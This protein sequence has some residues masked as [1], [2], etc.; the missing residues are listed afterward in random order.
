MLLGGSPCHPGAHWQSRCSLMQSPIPHWLGPSSGLTDQE[1][2]QRCGE[3]VEELRLWP[4]SLWVRGWRLEGL[5][6]GACHQHLWQHFHGLVSAFGNAVVCP[7]AEPCHVASAGVA[8][9]LPCLH[10][11]CQLGTWGTEALR[12]ASLSKAPYLGAK[13]LLEV[14]LE[15]GTWLEG[16]SQSKQE[17]A[18][19]HL[20]HGAMALLWE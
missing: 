9:R 8:P 2:W 14:S 4:V 18:A 17:G 20:G 7:A 16:S 12:S 10:P 1:T 11:C 15:P 5:G 13:D 3:G 19:P 6:K